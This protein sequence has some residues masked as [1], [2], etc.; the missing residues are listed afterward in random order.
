MSTS[1][2]NISGTLGSGAN[3]DSGPKTPAGSVTTAYTGVGALKTWAIAAYGLRP[4]SAAA[5]G[6]TITPT[7]GSLS[8]TGYAPTISVPQTIAPTAGAVAITGRTACVGYSITPANGAMTITGPPGPVI[9]VNDPLTTSVGSLL[10]T[11]YAPSVVQNNLPAVIAGSLLLTGYAPTVSVPQTITPSAGAL[12]L[13]NHYATW[14]PLNTA[15]GWTLSNGN[16]TLT[17]TSGNFSSRATVGVSSG[18]WY[19]E[20]VPTG[21]PAIF[22]GVIGI[23]NS[24]ESINAVLGASAN[25]WGYDST[26]LIIHSGGTTTYGGGYSSGQTIGMAL[27]MDAGTLTLYVNNV[28]QGVAVT[29]LTGIIY[30]MIGRSL[31]AVTSKFGASAFTYTPPAGFNGFY[32]GETPSISVTQTITPTA[33]SVLLTGVAPA[34]AVNQTITPSTGSLLLTGYAPSISVLQTITPTAGS[35]LITGSQ[36]TVQDSGATSFTIHPSS[37]SLAITGQAPSILVSVSAAPTAGSLLLTGSQPSLLVNTFIAP[38][39]GSCA[40]T[41]RTPVVGLGIVPS[42]GTLLLNGQTPVTGGSVSILP[43]SGSLLLS[44]YAP[45]V[46]NS[47]GTTI[48]TAQGVLLLTG[49][50]PTILVFNPQDI[51]Q[52]GWKL[53]DRF[54]S[55]KLEER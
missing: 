12:S 40:I 38:T 44:G 13:Y 3:Q 49:Y 20:H 47:T 41:G 42:S 8:L 50:T 39:A 29:G 11:G 28:S 17:S 19:A 23:G 1:R 51:T 22:T 36:P 15:S 26:G 21:N 33:G 32:S 52:Y 54:S 5:L 31:H 16:L 24:S 35:L 43:T 14:D 53:A 27:D 37:A 48:T 4:T 25:S 30:P 7:A 18:K 10:L 46:G 9:A 6:T 2:N 55:W 34:I 45:T